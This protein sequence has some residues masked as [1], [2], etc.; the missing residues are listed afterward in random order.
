VLVCLPLLIRMW[1]WPVPDFR[2]LGSPRARQF[3]GRM[4]EVVVIGIFAQ[5]N[6]LVLRLLA[7]L[8]E[9]GSVTHYHYATRVVDLA[10]GVI[11]VGVGS[12][13]LPELATAIA[14][15]DFEDFRSK[16]HQALRLAAVL[17]IPSAAFTAVLALPVTCVLFLHGEFNQQDAE[18]TAQTLQM[19]IPFM[20]ALGAVQIFK[21]AYFA[22]NDLQTLMRVGFLG[23]LLTASL[24][25]VLATRHGVAGLAAGLSLA[26]VGQGLIYIVAL[27]ARSG[28]AL[29]LPTLVS[30]LIRM[31]VASIPAAALAGLIAQWG[32]WSSGPS[33]MNLVYLSIAGLTGFSLYAVIASLIG[34]SEMRSILRRLRILK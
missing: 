5:L 20:L 28:I 8:L 2:G 17:L 13:A 34:V 18:A 10:Q 16:L 15:K 27:P 12:A 24:G 7:S 22:I 4:G 9:T 26:T 11:A 23:V 32:D 30:P 21:R 25:H 6:I 29:Q 14:G 33:L 19:M 1:G 31:G 3:V